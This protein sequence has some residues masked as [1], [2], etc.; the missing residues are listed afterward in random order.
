M[1][2]ELE[3]FALVVAADELSPAVVAWAVEPGVFFEAAEPEAFAL[4]SAAVA[5]SP[6]VAA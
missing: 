6:A 1:A 3:A 4:A 2:A 5:L